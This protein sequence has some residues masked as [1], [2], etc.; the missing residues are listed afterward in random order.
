MYANHDYY[1]TEYGG[2]MSADDFKR[3]ARRAERRIDSITGGKLQYAFPA[4]DR[5]IEA[6]KDC[7]CELAD[8]LWQIDSY[9]NASMESIGTVAQADGTVK[10]KV[11][12]SVSSG[13]ESRN[14]STSGIANTSISEAAKD[15]KVADTIIYGMVQDNLGGIPDYNG[16]NLLYA[17]VYP[18]S[19]KVVNPPPT[20]PKGEQAEPSNPQPPIDSDDQD[21]GSG[22]NN[23]TEGGATDN[24]GEEDD[25]IGYVDSIIVY[26][27]YT[28][29]TMQE[30]TYF[31][32]RFDN[33]R[34]EL[35]QGANQKASGMEN[36]SVCVVKIPNTN[37]PKPYKAPPVWLQ[38]TAE[39]M[40]GS[41]TLNKGNDFFVIAKKGDLG[42]DVDLP[43]GMIE[44]D[45]YEGY[46]DGFM[47]YVKVNYGYAFTV[48]TVDVYTVIPRFEIG[49]K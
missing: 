49:G 24:N 42:I 9:N 3:F 21:G 6:V 16:I 37:L 38:L 39:E 36:T 30:Q 31:G 12:T 18:Y 45:S 14:Y 19:T 35:T 17:G 33:V 10:G 1:I 34:I 48:D 47:G 46:D 20:Y 11:I 23:L 41:F 4:N 25:G 28:Y 32:T 8:F 43:A 40:L 5:D 26:N 7:V 27:Q 15:R 2:K 29:G 13:S 22:E 44:S